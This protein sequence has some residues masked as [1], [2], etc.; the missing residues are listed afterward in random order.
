MPNSPGATARATDD[1]FLEIVAGIH[2]ATLD[3]ARWPG[4]I[5][6]VSARTGNDFGGV[7]FTPS[8]AQSGGLWHMTPPPPG[9]MEAYHEQ[10]AV[11]DPFVLPMLARRQAGH[12]VYSLE[13]LFD[14]QA[15]QRLAVYHELLKR[16]DIEECTGLLVGDGVEYSSMSLFSP[17]KSRKDVAAAK[18]V[19][20]QLAPHFSCA[21]DLHYRLERAE[22]G[23]TGARAKLESLALAIL[24]LD[25]GGRAIGLNPAAETLVRTGAWLRVQDRRLVASEPE[26]LSDAV[27]RVAEA[28]ES[29]DIMLAPFAASGRP[30]RI[31]LMPADHYPEKPTAQASVILFAEVQPQPELA[32]AVARRL[33]LVHRLTAAETAVATALWQ[34][35]SPEDIA[36]ARNGSTS[37]VRTQIKSIAGKLGVS[38]Q[39]EIVRSVIALA[40]IA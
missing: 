28:K 26:K 5:H 15:F 12:Q 30:I 11:N 4:V 38:R 9:Y 34:G 39:T 20:A 14:R 32:A 36:A 27:R 29:I 33:R 18:R 22:A 16:H 40:S 25:Q 6:Q 24:W 21:V 2:A 8:R 23:A 10:F 7:I 1:W 13:D 31:T 19:L 37:T 3:P 17:S 35:E